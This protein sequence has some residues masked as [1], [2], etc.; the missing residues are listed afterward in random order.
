FAGVHPIV[1]IICRGRLDGQGHYC[2]TGYC[3]GRA[4]L[5]I[6]LGSLLR[7]AFPTAL[8]KKVG[9]ETGLTLHFFSLIVLA[10]V[11]TVIATFAGS[12]NDAPGKGG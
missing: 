12:V 11:R 7:L 4:C 10:F 1:D 6:P 2:L 8:P 5:V 9:P 3:D